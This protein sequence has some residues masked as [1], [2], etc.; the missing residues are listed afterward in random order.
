MAQE[1]STPMLG[2]HFHKFLFEEGLRQDAT[3]H[4]MAAHLGVK[5]ALLLVF[6]AF[7]F[8]A[9]STL[10]IVSLMFGLQLPRLGWGGAL[11]LALASMGVLLRSVWLEKY[12]VPPVL[13]L[14]REQALLFFS[15]K[16]ISELP[17]E[18]QVLRFQ[19]KFVNSLSRCVRD[20]F[21]ANTKIYFN[22]EV[23]CCLIVGSV[24]CLVGCLL[25]IIG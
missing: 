7:V 23:A 25:W 5:N 17:E 1:M 2:V 3:V 24:L 6:S 16:E 20:N 19:E 11:L 21:Q 10:V 15:L 8:A 22:I 4:K 12:R 13:P 14:L 18:Q 9:E